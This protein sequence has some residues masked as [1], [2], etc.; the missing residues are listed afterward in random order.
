MTLQPGD[1]VLFYT[2]GLT[3]QRNRQGEFFDI[4]RLC[5]EANG[6]ATDTCGQRLDRIFCRVSDF[7]D[8]REPDDK[9][10]MLLIINQI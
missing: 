9:T 1:F 5:E 3:E 2:D 8:D 7:G 10:A 4:E 6:P